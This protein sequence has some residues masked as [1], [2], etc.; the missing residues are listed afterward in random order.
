MVLSK[1]IQQAWF[2]LS[3]FPHFGPAR[4]MRIYSRCPDPQLLFG[5]EARPVLEQAHIENA[6]IE[7][8]LSIQHDPS[9]QARWRTIEDE[10]ISITVFGSATYPPLLST[11]AHPP[12]VL[13][14]RGPLEQPWQNM[15]A[16][17]GTRSLSP[18]G[19]AIT[20]L[21]VGQI[22]TRGVGVV[23]GLAFGIDALSHQAA[24]EANGPTVA[25]IA[26]GVDRASIF[27]SAHSMLAERI[28]DCGG[29]VMSE[30]PPGTM[31]LKH[32]FPMRNRIIAGL[33]RATLVIEA[34]TQSGALITARSALEENRDVFAVPGPITTQTSAGT[35]ALIRLGAHCVTNAN[36]LLDDL[37]LSTV[38]TAIVPRRP[39]YADINT[40][41]RS[42][43]DHLTAEPMEIDT[44]IRAS[45]L[46][47][48]DVLSTLSLME[49]K[50]WV[51]SVGPSLF[52]KV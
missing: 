5:P 31:P 29:C 11:I 39:Q 49:L 9:W 43:L 16:V 35:N 25:V 7:Q 15:I 20:P 22:A 38:R 19:R 32:Y 36:D 1:E 30:F 45:G 6:L 41:E 12:V 10:H 8:F 24:L 18:Y 4:L 37:E 50:G 14:H 28:V 42:L 46:P 40:Q 52:V 13:F 44:I 17:V 47:A 23:S 26:S 27:P 3:L 2:K 21:L 48:T 51:R 33:V 34:D